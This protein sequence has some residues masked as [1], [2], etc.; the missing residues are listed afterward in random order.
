MTVVELDSGALATDCSGGGGVDVIGLGC[1]LL[2]LAFAVVASTF[3]R[4]IR[5][6]ENI[7]IDE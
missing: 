2:S 3:C 1:V 4:T 6:H 5:T 7:N